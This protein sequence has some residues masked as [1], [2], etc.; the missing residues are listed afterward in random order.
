MNKLVILPNGD[1]VIITECDL[2][3]NKHA[4]RKFK[5]KE[6]FHSAY[7]YIDE[8]ITHELGDG[9]WNICYTEP[10]GTFMKAMQLCPN[11]YKKFGIE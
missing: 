9:W 5:P 11:C 4:G 6:S 8:Q 1:S 3:N 2:C 10:G 7:Y